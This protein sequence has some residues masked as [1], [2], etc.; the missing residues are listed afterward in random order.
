MK[1]LM[2]RVAL[3]AATVTMTGSALVAATGPASAAALPTAQ[4]STHPGT[5]VVTVT[6]P[7]DLF[8]IG[9]GWS[10]SDG[11][12]EWHG[13]Q[14]RSGHSYWRSDDNGHQL[15]YDGN[16]LYDWHEGRWTAVAQADEHTYA[17]NRWHFEQLWTVRVIEDPRGI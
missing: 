15:R 7:G 10:L 8:R 16:R 11:Q 17:F 13:E 1:K 14:D 4:H 2:T 6:E 9:E 12:R 3:A 5:A